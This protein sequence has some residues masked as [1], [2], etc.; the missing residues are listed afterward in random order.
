MTLDEITIL[1]LTNELNRLF[2]F[3]KCILT[4]RA[5]L[6]AIEIGQD[7]QLASYKAEG[8]N[9]YYDEMLCTSCDLEDLARLQEER[10]LKALKA[11]RQSG[12]GRGGY[13]R[14]SKR[15]K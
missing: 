10:R 7:F 6:K 15:R 12:F 5:C 8:M 3:A 14:L 11:E 4:C 9:Y 1:T 2:R 13:S